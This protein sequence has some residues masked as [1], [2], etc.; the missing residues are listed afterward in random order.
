MK[1]ILTRALATGG[2]LVL[3]GGLAAELQSKA[4]AQ[5]APA[6]VA[7][8]NFDK[9]PTLYVIGYS[10]LDTQWCWTY[11]QV[12]GEFLPNTLH[13]N[14]ALFDKYPDYTFNW[15]GSNRYRLMKEYY[16]DD[17]K[18]LKSYIAAGRWYPCGANVEEGDVDMPSEESVVRNILYGND[19]FYK[20]FGKRSNE[21]MIPD[22]F[23]F[24]ASLPSIFAH[25]GLKGFVTQKLT[26]GSAV[27]IPF[28]V[29]QWVGTDGQSVVAALN[30][31]AYTSDIKDDLSHDQDWINRVQADGQ[32]S[33]VYVDYRFYG[34]GDRGG[35][36]RESDVQ[37]AEKS[38]HSGGPLNIQI[39]TADAMFDAITPDQKSRL[40]VYKGDILLINHSTGSLTSEAAMKQW[41]LE[42]EL[43]GDATERSSVAADWLGAL[44]YDKDRIT[45]AWLRFLP[46]QFH[47]LMAGTALPKAYEYTWNDEI[48]AMNEFAGVLQASVNGVSQGLDTKGAGIP[49]V[50]YNPLS[51]EREDPVQATVTFPGTL[52]ASVEVYGPG[53][54]HTPVKSQI[55]AR[56][57]S[58]LTV[59]FLA[60]APSIGY[61]TYHIVGTSHPAAAS[62]EL[63]ISKTGLENA[64]Y[65]ISLNAAGDIA[66]IYDKL[67]HKQILSA[68]ARLAFQTENPEQYPAWNMD[69]DDQNKP[70]RGYVDGAPT[71]KVVENGPVRV[72]LQVE[73]TAE[74]ST[75]VQTI[76]LASGSAG[77]RVEIANHIR[78]FGRTCALKA[79]FPLTVSNPMATYNWELGTIQRGNNDPKKFEVPSH[80]WIDLTDTSD[81]YG[82]SILT[83]PKYG[84]DKPDD[85]TLRLT[86][87]YTPG[88]RGG[89][90]HQA[91]QDHGVHDFV[92]GLTGHTGDWRTGN[93]Q[94]QAWRLDQ[95]M[96]AFQTSAHPGALGSE[97]SLAKVSTPQVQIE[98]LKQAEDSDEV[99]V[100]L[101]ELA[102]NPVHGARLSFARPIVSA[103]EVNGQELPV[104]AAV[105]SG[106]QLVFD[107]DGYRPRAY[108]L[109]LAPAPVRLNA[110]AVR[111]LSLPLDTN[112]VSSAP[113]KV[114][115]DFDGHGDALAGEQ[116]PASVNSDGITFRLASLE[117]GAKNA[118]SCAGQTLSVPAGK[119]RKLYFLAASGAG[120]TEGTFTVGYRKVPLTIQSFDGKIGQWDN[121]VWLGK[122]PELTYDWSNRLIGITPGY[123]KRDTVAWYSDHTRLADGTND[124]YGFSYLFRYSLDVPDGVTQV[125]LPV[126]KRIKIMAA[127]LQ[128]DTPVA[129]TPAQPLY[130]TLPR[131]VD[132]FAPGRNG[133]E[134][135][136]S[137]PYAPVKVA[138]ADTLYTFDG[139]SPGIT[140][141]SHPGLPVTGTAPWTINMFVWVDKTPEELTTLGGFGDDTD[142][143]AT[144]RYLIE[145][146]G[147]I[148]FWGSGIDVSTG[149]PYDLGKW[150]MVTAT[151]DGT[152][153]RIYKNGQEIK[154]ADV[155]FDDAAPF[156]NIAPP[157]PWS[158]AHRF[159]GKIQGF[160]IWNNGLH[161]ADVTAL[162][163]DMPK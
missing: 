77:S 26:W 69:W 72:A 12:I 66:G 163:A 143:A 74:G 49:I 106:G 105:L 67:A 4:L 138:A 100:R 75:F 115:G 30:A 37:N 153:L 94:W 43:L 139:T 133:I 83:G 41:N 29:G 99:I 127:S 149:V 125:T 161:P 141:A 129:V 155:S 110:P 89:F 39:G 134:A 31:G 20:E 119:N 86:L 10:H 157:G 48:L 78:W 159:Q 156:V 146:H 51:I 123:V 160:S 6:P 57:G 18:T 71:V 59:L 150:Q 120:D 47:D 121:R 148:H 34:V 53:G 9:D 147:G 142:S 137:I 126:N 109:R 3:V 81:K 45:D 95:P 136:V 80:K 64:R 92:Y 54:S 22:C 98:A 32:K 65:Q 90:Q 8:L 91:S 27:G 117:A 68:P 55:L 151:Y 21:F 62:G 108:A 118:V 25:C 116:L 93:T 17:Y 122:V 145:Y 158:K 131:A 154:K 162:L 132:E 56:N 58:N 128:T 24:P 2:A 103:R 63:K 97:W 107:M 96:V 50:V 40:P 16:P 14:F 102:G 46:G 104:G 28:N 140:L 152:A 1:A 52:P 15:T 73:R 124:I 42:N 112:V 88:V 44:P 101:N 35:S 144:Q 82:V 36:C 7:P 60:S 114:N 11:P 79:T 135:P 13:Q 5:A 85:S 113:G 130:V 38:L 76:R 33:G 61:T 84:S 87:L 19:F 23:G 111:P 70:P